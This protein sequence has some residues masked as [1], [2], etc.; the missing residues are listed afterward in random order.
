M[1][2]KLAAFDM[3]STLIQCEVI[4]ELAR[5]ND[6][7]GQVARITE[8]AM[9]GKLDFVSSLRER[10]K[11]LKG[12]HISQ[13]NE[14][15]GTLPY[16]TGLSELMNYLKKHNYY[17]AILSGGF[18]F[19]AEQIR[20]DYGFDFVRCNQLELINDR[21]TGELIGEIVD[22]NVKAT[23]ILEIAEANQ[24]SI[25]H[26]VAIGDGMNDLE[27]LQNTKTGIAFC[28]KHELAEKA[29]YVISTADLSLVIE[30]LENQQNSLN[31]VTIS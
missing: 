18:S 30:I 5:M 20:N 2:A 12:I 13:I 25:E 29:S 22:K 9:R 15:K 16:T 6:K 14:F 24:I 4:D 3:D 31:A 10:V 7:Y 19:F 1:F 8:E 17:T 21:L 26:T 28:P 27:M 23:S 11:Q